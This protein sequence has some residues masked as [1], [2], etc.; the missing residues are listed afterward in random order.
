MSPEPRPEQV[1][2]QQTYIHRR[3]P[4]QCSCGEHLESP[5]DASHA[6]HLA[7]LQ[8]D[9]LRAAG[10]AVIALPEPTGREIGTEDE[11]G[12]VEWTYP[13]GT[14]QVFDDGII[15]WHRWHFDDPSKLRSAAA[16]LLAAA[17]AAEATH[18]THERG[19]YEDLGIR[20]P[21]QTK[22]Q[23]RIIGGAP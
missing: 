21:A 15:G 11:N 1:L 20:D 8:R 4:G 17:A 16:A 19:L 14:V 22:A 13:H 5:S 23:R 7:D 6:R 12:F 9:A 10:F 18:P 2:A 3:S